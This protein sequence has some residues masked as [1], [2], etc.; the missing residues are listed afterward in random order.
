[1]DP[2]LIAVFIEQAPSLIFGVIIIWFVLKLTERNAKE[3]LDRD[4]EW[5][6]WLANESQQNR[7]FFR[8]Y[9]VAQNDT[10]AR[11]AEEIKANTTK[12]AELT[13]IMLEHD[14]RAREFIEV[15]VKKGT[16]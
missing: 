16:G 10:T 7:E 8:E 1:M 9:K 2:N 15:T 11:L 4:E 6:R 3:R 12:L 13:V 14:R 5:R